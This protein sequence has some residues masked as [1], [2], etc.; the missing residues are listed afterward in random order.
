[1]KAWGAIGYHLVYSILRNVPFQQ[2][3]AR[4]RAASVVKSFL[5]TEKHNLEVHIKTQHG[6][7]ISQSQPAIHIR[8]VIY[9]ILQLI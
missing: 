4:A 3:N 8:G 2:D 9:Q 1:M 5:C 7:A 6:R